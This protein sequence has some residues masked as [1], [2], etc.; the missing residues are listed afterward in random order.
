[1]ESSSFDL[2]TYR[3][4][5]P[6]VSGLTPVHSFD[7]IVNQAAPLPQSNGTGPSIAFSQQFDSHNS[8][9][10]SV[11]RSANR[12]K[13][14]MSPLTTPQFLT[15]RLDPDESLSDWTLTVASIASLDQKKN[16]RENANEDRNQE[17]T[18][19]GITS[20]FFRAHGVDHP[21]KKYFVHRTQLAVGPRKSEYFAKLFRN[22]QKKGSKANGTRIELR[23]CAANAFPS[24]LD[25]MYSPPG[26]PVDV[27]TDSAVALR[28]LATC[29]GIRE[30]F[31]SVTEFIKDDLCTDTAA[32]YLMEAASFRHE[33]LFDVSR[34]VCS[35]N[36]EVI[37]FSQI[38][39]LSADLFEKVILSDELVC[40]SEVLSSRVASYCRCRPG[41]VDVDMLKRITCSSKMPRIAPE[42]SLFFLHLL[43]EIDGDEESVSTSAPSKTQDLY[44]RCLVA[45]AEIVRMAVETKQAS[46]SKKSIDSRPKR[47]AV[48]EYN[49]LS[50]ATKVDLL[51]HALSDSP[52]LDELMELDIA[53]KESTKK[54]AHDSAK[55]LQELEAEMLRMRRSYEK[56]LTLLQ[57][58]VDAQ[59]QEIQSYATEL[60]KF[61]RVPNAFRAPSQLPECTFQGKPKFDEYGSSIYGEI[62]PSAMPIFGRQTRDGWVYREDQ[63]LNDGRQV[64]ALWPMY[65]YKGDA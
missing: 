59:E 27:T 21:T 65:F 20:S 37:K 17:S 55:R 30:L 61:S 53:R 47:I 11:H 40:S 42:A 14:L 32:T 35:E 38:V 29:F 57:A 4:G 31:D 62:P 25:F 43:S 5:Q 54:H 28:H 9:T 19:R 56:K 45:S 8:P 16:E 34:K 52:T 24:M 46:P 64:H 10:M 12:K 36:F 33:K 15:W 49:S 50:A 26:S 39:I 58:T 44:K 51:E 63:L 6:T 1:M 7:N 3:F 23:P 22:K 48:K 2:S 18:G 60:S 13:T 41:A